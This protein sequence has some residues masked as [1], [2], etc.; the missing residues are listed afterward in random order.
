MF[1]LTHQLRPRICIIEAWK[2][3]LPA[4]HR[5]RLRPPFCLLST[6]NL[7]LSS[8]PDPTEAFFFISNFSLL[9]PNGFFR[10]HCGK[11]SASALCSSLIRSSFEWPEANRAIRAPSKM[12]SLT[13]ALLK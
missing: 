2:W 6:F 5:T 4:A 12:H 8:V 11:S 9:S 7:H 1:S 10:S 13:P 3:R